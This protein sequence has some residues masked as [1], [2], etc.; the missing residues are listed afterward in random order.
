MRA[1]R[2]TRATSRR[3]HVTATLGLGL[4]L[5]TCPKAN[6]ATLLWN[7]SP[8]V[9]LGLYWLASRP[10]TRGALAVIR[11]PEP[12]RSLADSRGYL[13]AGTLLIKPIVARAGDVVCRHGPI[14]TLHGRVMAYAR[15]ADRAG[16]PLPRWSGCIRLK[17]R[18]AFVLSA[19]SDGF[20]SRYIGPMERRHVVGTALP[21]WP[22]PTE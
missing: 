7:T 4:L 14:V 3:L 20:D 5:L 22:T 18:Q 21:V 12:Y 10:P 1:P 19:D 13:P 9:P 6:V 8:S 15:R 16:R 2:R 11:L 17:A